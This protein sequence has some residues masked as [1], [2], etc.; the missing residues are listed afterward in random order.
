M[1]TFDQILA[2][3][4]NYGGT[5]LLDHTAHVVM[6]IE[7]L[8]RG[9]YSEFDIELAKKGAVLHDL[10]KAHPHF[11]NKISHF[12][13]GSLKE[14]RDQSIIHRHEL[15]SL[16]FLPVFPKDEWDAL[17]DMVVGHHKSIENGSKDRGILDLDDKYRH[18]KRNHLEKWEEWSPNC[19]QIL[20]KFGYEV[21]KFQK[22]NAEDALDYV[23]EYCE[24]KPYNWSKWKG[25]LMAADHFASAFGGNTEK[26][27]SK[28]FETPNL[29]FYN[30]PQ[31]KS[32]LFPLSLISVND[33]RKHTLVV[34][35]TGAG[36]T[37]F[38]LKR[39]KE[40]IFYTLP[41]QASIN[42]MWE[43]FKESIPNED[44]RL[45]H[46]TSK[47][48]VGKN[49]EEKII[50]PLTGST[51]KVLTPHQIASIIFGISGFESVMLDLQGCDIILDEIHTYSDYSK[52]MVL[53]IV[54]TLLRLN[55]KIHIGTATMPSVLY[56][57]LLKILGGQNCV[58]EVSLPQTTLKD[59]NRHKIYKEEDENCI[60]PILDNAINN[61]E[62][63]LVIYNTIKAAQEAFESI[64][65][66][67]PDTPKMLIHSRFKR[68]DRVELEAKLKNE[69]NGDGSRK[70]GNGIKPC[71]VVS[72]Q[73][74]EVSLDISF[75]RM[76]TQCAPLDSLIQRF[77]RVNRK[78]TKQ[79]IGNL[80]PIH[81]IAPGKRTL[82]Y[83]KETLIKS[84]EQLPD[85]STVLQEDELQSKINTVYPELDLKEIDIH[86]IFKNNQY[87]LK[88]LT[89]CSKAVLI[90]ALEIEG[91]S[92]IL[93]E[94][95][96]KYLEATWEERI[97]ME[98]PI[99]WKTIARHHKKYEQ[100]DVGS[101]PFVVPQNV[102]EYKMYG[103][104]LVEP[105]NFL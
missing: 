78:R 82:P 22:E 103:L 2:K 74:V 79:T 4:I 6:A 18:W 19:F 75:D 93:E 24:N 86:L 43:R 95:R 63:V 87:T 102:D 14:E 17:I 67:Y 21:N 42:A 41:F 98:I 105:D 72:T 16:A 70:H 66:S 59:F 28:L 26:N 68:I 97:N 55:C 88:E 84:F 62:K 80:K 76:I 10:G 38:L 33:E 92:C 64:H 30:N 99:N 29:T 23:V 69:F 34:A 36:K 9:F 37:D 1:K 13:A 45:L 3:S 27:L 60:I 77:G 47:I 94:D 52:A 8:A 39:C 5:T 35:P 71:I 104:Q 90:E 85:H 58:Y 53:E 20:N 91:A 101:N 49:I 48:V 46:A 12:N 50:Q 44:I 54:K 61:S 11:Q 25:L 73:V 100:L 81:V 65:Q 89:H 56:N 96:E 40:R 51:I 57:E 7:R 83:N 15:S 31:R 32:D